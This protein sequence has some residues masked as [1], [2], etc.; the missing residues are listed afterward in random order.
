MIPEVYKKP[1]SQGFHHNFPAT[2]KSYNSA[3]EFSSIGQSRH[4]KD[5]VLCLL[6]ILARCVEVLRLFDFPLK[7][8][9][10]LFEPRRGEFERSGFRP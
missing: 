2:H 8:R 4:E 3:V 10:E 5:L 1:E 7:P 6:R 9:S